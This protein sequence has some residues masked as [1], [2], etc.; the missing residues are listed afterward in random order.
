MATT[1]QQP[2]DAAPGNA[3]PPEYSRRSWFMPQATATAL[4]RA[5]DDLHFD[6]RVPKATAL[7]AIIETGLAHLDEAR[8]R[9]AGQAAPPSS[10]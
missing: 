5:V 2:E 7:A 8:K 3:Q 10:R 4:A 9:T 1:K 6:Q